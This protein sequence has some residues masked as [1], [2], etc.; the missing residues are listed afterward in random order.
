M[1]FMNEALF[2]AHI[3]V[4][5][6]FAMLAL[7]SGKIAL[8]SFLVLQAIL[9]NLFVVKQMTLFGCSVTCSD[10][11]AVGGI[12]TLN[13]LQ[14]YFGKGSAEQ[15]IR[16]SLLGLIFFALMSQVHLFYEPILTD[17]T[18]SAFQTIFSS[19]LRIVFASIAVFYLVQKI[20]VQLFSFLKKYLP[21]TRLPIRIAISLIFSQLIDTIFFS[22]L[23]LYGLVESL[24]DII[25]WS[26]FVKCSIIA[27]SSFLITLSKR[28][29]KNVPI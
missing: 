19:S 18:H 4:V 12:L 24:F 11:F 28:I 22:F 29:V 14:E 20:D 9:A 27:C 15:A 5:A 8:I 21:T 17:M 6:G 1:F 26:F 25:L 3:L 10:V 7:R 23:A 2:F 16:I 13:L